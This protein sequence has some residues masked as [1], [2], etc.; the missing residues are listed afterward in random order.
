AD[1]L[2]GGYE[3][4]T[5]MLL[6][7]KIDSVPDGL[8]NFL[9]DTLLNILPDNMNERS[10]PARCRRFLKNVKSS[11]LDRYAGIIN[12][13]HDSA[14]KRLYSPAMLEVAKATPH[15]MPFRNLLESA[16][17]ENEIERFMELEFH[18]YLPGDVLAKVDRASMAT[19][20][21]V[22]SPFL[23]HEVIEFAASLPLEWKLKGFDRKHIL[24]D[25]FRDLI[26][27]EI[28]FRKKMGFGIPVGEWLREGLY[29]K[30]KEILFSDTAQAHGF[31][32]TGNVKNLLDLHVNRKIDA[33]YQLWTLLCFE[34]WF[35]EHA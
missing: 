10:L 9:V 2:F 11:G 3:R 31:F 12:R 19:S 27:E 32:N 29:E 7:Q 17:S 34:M 35:R 4:Y 26:P 33:S 5:A 16:S 28:L 13:W 8:K 15:T 20:L 21:E 18:S 30:A 23:D 14:L 6:A 25:A 1:E 24:A 22:R